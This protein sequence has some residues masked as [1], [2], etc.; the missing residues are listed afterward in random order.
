MLINTTGAV[1]IASLGV[2]DY[3][4]WL[5]QWVYTAVAD[6]TCK[7]CRIVCVSLSLSL[8]QLHF[9]TIIQNLQ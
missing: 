7:S 5:W 4:V 6:T 3:S 2:V 8:L 9:N 1:I